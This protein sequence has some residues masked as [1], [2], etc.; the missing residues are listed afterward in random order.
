MQEIKPL[1]TDLEY[2]SSKENRIWFPMTGTQRK[3]ATVI[4]INKTFSVKEPLAVIAIKESSSL[5]VIYPIQ[6]DMQR[7]LFHLSRL[8]E[9]MFGYLISPTSL[10]ESWIIARPKEELAKLV[11]RVVLNVRYHRDFFWRA[12]A[13]NS[14]FEALKLGMGNALHLSS[15]TASIFRKNGLPTRIV[16]N[17]TFFSGNSSGHW[18]VEV[19]LNND[20]ISCDASVRTDVLTSVLKEAS[21][22]GFKDE[23]KLDFI[24]E[25]FEREV[26]R[27]ATITPIDEPR[28]ADKVGQ[29]IIAAEI[30]YV[31]PLDQ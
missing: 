31:E 17:P 27:G 18:W 3:N 28:F 8:P 30:P 2:C 10:D 20:W 7:Y 5:S 13:T 9:I 26:E 4:H 29:R 16:G 24:I 23:E 15:L 12:L 14:P 19:F 22:H 1:K 25:S 21:A 6:P 11:A